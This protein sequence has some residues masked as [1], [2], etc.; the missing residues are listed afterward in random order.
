[1]FEINQIVR[2]KVAGV[3]VVVGKG[4]VFGKLHYSVKEVNPANLAETACG[5][6]LYEEETLRPY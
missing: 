5:E 2:G 1:M 6:S 3:F 4:I